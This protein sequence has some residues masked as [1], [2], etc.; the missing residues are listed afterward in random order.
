MKPKLAVDS[1]VPVGRPRRDS[2]LII[3]SRRRIIEHPSQLVA[4][5]MDCSAKG[6]RVS[7]SV[8]ILPVMRSESEC[9]KP[10]SSGDKFEHTADSHIHSLW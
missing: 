8:M 7:Q 6:A 2:R 4:V 3:T 1:A 9:E 10:L 5:T